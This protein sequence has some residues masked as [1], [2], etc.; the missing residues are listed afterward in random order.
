[1]GY[2]PRRIRMVRLTKIYTKT[3]DK[4]STALGD[5]S[6][7]SKNDS[8]IRAYAAVDEANSN[9]GVVLA[10]PDL[11]IDIR[12]ILNRIQNE[13]FDVGADL[14]T[15]VVGNPKY[16]P[17]RITEPSILWLEAVIDEYNSTLSPL[18]SFILPAGGPV[19][20]HLH[21]AR[22]VVRR[23]ER[24]TWA[25][26]EEYGD[27]VSQ[28][29]AKYLNRLSDLLFV[30]ARVASEYD[31]LWIPGKNRHADNDACQDCVGHCKVC[32]D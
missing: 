22:T 5:M 11:A 23:A 8:R 30:L 25:A 20:A 19:S 17:L 29:A 3:G 16:E 10:Q 18:K 32:G 26:I 31:E 1:M 28:L 15:P 14:S 6:R 24:D 7:V 2:G 27:G 21:V 12:N 4:G 9:I 13:M